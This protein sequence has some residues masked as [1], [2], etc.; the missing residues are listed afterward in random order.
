M[1]GQQ[2]GKRGVPVAN[3]DARVSVWDSMTSSPVNVEPKKEKGACNAQIRLLFFL[4][5]V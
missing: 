4:H 1:K 3:A 2:E 5:P